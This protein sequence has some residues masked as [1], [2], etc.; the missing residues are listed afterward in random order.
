MLERLRPFFRPLNLAAFATLAAVGYTMH[1]EDSAPYMPGVWALVLL[2]AASMLVHEAAERRPY[3]R[4]G[5]YVAQTACT[6]TLIALASRSGVAPVLLVIL[7]SQLAMDYPPRVVVPLAIAFNLG[8]YGLLKWGGHNAPATQMVLYLGFEAFAALTTYY[9]RS[10]ECARDRL[11][12][13][14]ADLLATRALLA[15]TARDN[16]RLRVARELHDVAG[17]KLT[18]MTLN[19]RAM[20]ADPAFAQRPEVALA[21]QLSSE[22]LT[23]IRGIVQAMRHDDHGLDLA[24]AL[25]ALAAPM[26]RPS[27]RLSIAEHVRVTDPAVAEA[28]LRLVQEALTN[29]ARHADADV[30]KV[31]IGS[32]G[33]QLH[34]RVEDDGL[35][36]G[37][38]REGNGLSGMRER[39]VAAGGQLALST[40]ERGALRI[41]ARLPA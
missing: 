15:D 28:V 12:Q 21:Q 16:E 1:F 6:F 22:L 24:T 20:A 41:D 32:E 36:R 23:D 3:L 19:L 27:L 4:A 14:N 13:V 10:A 37:P 9:A 35:L 26:P 5:V 17:H 39:V 11:A 8:A 38:L 31:S 33:G 40:G 2:F 7:V 30:V 34:V 29:S 25:R 18:A